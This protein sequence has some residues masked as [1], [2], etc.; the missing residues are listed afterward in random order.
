MA[1]FA[2]LNKKNENIYSVTNIIIA[3]DKEQAEK[4]LNAMLVEYTEDNPAAI[5]WDYDG[6]KFYPLVVAE[7]PAE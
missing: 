3:D 1:T 6:E 2:V 7:V 5:G 4:D